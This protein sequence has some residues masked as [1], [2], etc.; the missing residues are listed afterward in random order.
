MIEMRE[1]GDQALL[2]EKLRRLLLYDGFGLNSIVLN[3][4]S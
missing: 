4:A 3:S 1:K 2:A